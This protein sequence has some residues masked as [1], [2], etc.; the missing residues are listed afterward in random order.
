MCPFKIDS[1]TPKQKHVLIDKGTDLPNL[2]DD[3]LPETPGTFLCRAC[4]IALFRGEHQFA[5]S[6]GWP[7]FDDEI[8][9]RIKILFESD[10]VRE[11]IVCQQCESHLGHVF[12]KEGYTAKNIRHCVNDTSI[13]F[14]P[15]LDVLQTAEIIV[16][17]GCFWG[18]EY[19]LGKEL[20]VLKVESGYTGGHLE[21]PGYQSVCQGESGHTEAVR[22][23]FDEAKTNAKNL[24]QAFFEL[25]TP[26]VEKEGALRKPRQYRSMVFYYDEKQKKI[27]EELINYL[28]NKFNEKVATELFPVRPFWPAES[29]HQNY[30]QKHN[31]LAI[32][33]QRT[34]RFNTEKNK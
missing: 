16:A 25:H 20:G 28:E 22:V 18:I 29:A 30:Y 9:N 7:S 11:E 21:N 8:Q 24:Y 5:S 34:A 26:F 10:G 32:C 1:L 3:F 2:N 15:N 14:V 4:G 27:A 13:E 23:V 12:R 31:D 19:F 6:C 33:H 17:G